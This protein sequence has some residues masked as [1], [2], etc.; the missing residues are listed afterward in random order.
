LTPWESYFVL[1]LF[2]LSNVRIHL[3]GDLIGEALH[4][5]LA[6]GIVVGLVIGKPVGFFAATRMAAATGIGRLPEGVT[7]RMI[8]GVGGV[9]GIGFTISLFIAELAFAGAER[10]E[11]AALAILTASLI[12]GLFGY[13]TLWS[14][15]KDMDVKQTTD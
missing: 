15:A 11:I 4:S 10:T 9:A 14:A 12:A 7:W 8:V 2:A 6:L 13:V 3:S 1:P 5:P